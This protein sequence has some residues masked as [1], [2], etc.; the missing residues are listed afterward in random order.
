MGSYG[1]DW[2]ST[3]PRTEDE[4]KEE[5]MV[6]RLLSDDEEDAPTVGSIMTGK[7]EKEL[8]DDTGDV[9]NIQKQGF[10][11]GMLGNL[12]GALGVLI[13]KDPGKALQQVLESRQNYIVE[14]ERRAEREKER[15]ETKE[16]RG[17]VLGF[18]KEKQARKEEEFDTTQTFE[19]FA[20][21]RAHELAVLTQKDAQGM[22]VDLLDLQNRQLSVKV[23]TFIKSEANANARAKF[24]AGAAMEREIVRGTNQIGYATTMSNLKTNADRETLAR[25][26]QRTMMFAG[27]S[28]T[29]AKGIESKLRAGVDLD[30]EERAIYDKSMTMNFDE[31]SGQKALYSLAQFIAE[32]HMKIRTD[33]MG[34]ALPGRSMDEIGQLITNGTNEF[35]DAMGIP[36]L[37]VSS[38]TPQEG[39]ARLQVN[40]E[41]QLRLHYEEL[42]KT[43]PEQANTDLTQGVLDGYITQEQA[44]TMRGV[45]SS[46]EQTINEKLKAKEEAFEWFEEGR[47]R[48]LW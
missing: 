48:P 37:F 5:S 32:E 45:I 47:K 18:E 16:Y 36:R 28:V 22:S 41:Q 12:P 26:M 46:E 33:P 14:Q 11:Q 23:I 25:Q 31:D 15:A 38:E 8:G 19:E 44:D 35:A 29:Q 3:E 4:K 39:V 6:Q 7:T 43:D 40:A 24:T 20:S 27:A 13:S 17:K 2:L 10:F 9:P 21:K 42:K 34:K 1:V 30:S